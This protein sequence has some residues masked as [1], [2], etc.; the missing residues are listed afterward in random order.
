MQW[1]KRTKDGFTLV[2]LL[3]V[4]GII[5]L[6]I[7]IL[8]PAL[9]RARKQA[10][11][12]SC[13]SNSRQVTYAALAYAN[14]WNER[15]PTRIN[16]LYWLSAYPLC[17]LSYTTRLPVIGWD[18]ATIWDF[19]TYQTSYSGFLGVNYLGGWAFMMRDYL[20]NDMDV[21]VCPDGWYS[22]DQWITKWNGYQDV[23]GPGIIWE[24]DSDSL[25]SYHVGYN[26]LPHRW[27]SE[28]QTAHACGGPV[29]VTDDPGRVA[30]TASES[31]E[32]QVLSDFN[33]FSVEYNAGCGQGA[34]P[35]PGGRCGVGGNHVGTSYKG[36]RSNETACTPDVF[37]PNIGREENPA[38]MPLGQNSSRIDART[39]WVP[40]QDWEYYRYSTSPHA[41]CSYWTSF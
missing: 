16:N 35:G 6:L 37:P 7:A 28:P 2:E 15:L 18:T 32:L 25:I 3:V 30:K 38:Q 26:W 23:Y 5:A 39:K 9:S 8:M 11:A 24:G 19:N 27:Q 21:Y 41:C 34:A 33:I 36:L 12:V 17:W 40:W 1:P 14:D 10:L 31:P 29:N 13:G 22:K 4:I 20:K